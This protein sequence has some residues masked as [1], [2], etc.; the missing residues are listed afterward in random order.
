MHFKNTVFL[1]AYFLRPFAPSKTHVG[2]SGHL[3][4]GFCL[5]TKAYQD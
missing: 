2:I 4:F 3:S 5:T 1:I